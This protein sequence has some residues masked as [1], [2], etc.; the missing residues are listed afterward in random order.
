[1][2]RAFSEPLDRPSQLRFPWP[3]H[4]FSTAV[5]IGSEAGPKDPK[6]PKVRS[7]FMRTSAMV[8]LGH[9]A[10]MDG[11]EGRLGHRVKRRQ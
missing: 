5:T 11:N 9:T 6:D 2:T 8:G 3:F 4:A 7:K 10:M 1:M